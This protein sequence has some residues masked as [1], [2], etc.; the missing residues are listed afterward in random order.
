MLTF[1]LIALGVLITFMA[2]CL[3]IVKLDPYEE[4][5]QIGGDIKL[6]SDDKVMP[7]ETLHI[8]Y[9]SEGRFTICVDI[10]ID[11]YDIS[12]I[13]RV[14][15]NDMNVLLDTICTMPYNICVCSQHIVYVKNGVAYVCS[16]SAIFILIY[17]ES[18]KYWCFD[19]LYAPKS[20]FAK[21]R[22]FIFFKKRL[23]QKHREFC[24]KNVQNELCNIY[25]LEE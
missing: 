19:V 9:F 23:K 2:I 14:S 6:D 13:N 12:R 7:N 5:K 24:S 18:C 8:S 4:S 15:Y 20:I 25:G 16:K 17:K 3:L 10:N 1:F 21:M 11:D 22:Y